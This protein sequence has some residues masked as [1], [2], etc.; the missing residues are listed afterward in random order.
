M[1]LAGRVAVITGGTK[2]IGARIAESFLDEGAQVMCAARDATPVD[3][4]VAKG[5]DAVGFHA[6]DVRD[7]DSMRALMEAAQERFGGLDV[8]VANAGISRPAPTAALPAEVWAEVVDTN[9]TGVFTSVQAALPYLEKS[10]AGR[11]IAV[12]SALSTR[13]VYAGASYCATKA[14][15]DMLVRVWSLEMIEKGITVNALSPGFI[16]EGIGKMLRENTAV[17]DMFAPKMAMGRPGT[18]AEVGAAAVFLAGPDSSY[19]NG[20]ILEVNGGLRW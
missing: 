12:S 16:D 18:G 14:A 20:H 19:V 7:P 6:A 5:G 1:R 17:W 4:L 13:P 9:L 10:T 8:L 11:I 15:V 3:T 2:G